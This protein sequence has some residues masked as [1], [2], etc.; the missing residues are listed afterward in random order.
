MVKEEYSGGRWIMC[1]RF[2]LISNLSEV[3][4]V[5]PVEEISRPLHR[6][7]N[8]S[9][10]TAVS[11]LVR[12]EK[13]KLVQFRWGQV[14]PWAREGKP[15]REM[16]NAR[17]ETV[18]SKPAFRESFLKRRCLVLSNGYY[19][20]KRDGKGK[21][22][23]FIHLDGN[24]LFAFAG[25]YDR[26]DGNALPGVALLT[27]EPAPSIRSIH[28]RMPVILTGGTA[29]QWIGPLEGGGK[30]LLP[31]LKPYAGGDLSAYAVS[32][33]VNAPSHD[34]PACIAPRPGG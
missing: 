23:Y 15:R 7:F 1:G 19:E 11:A 18:A 21:I 32:T 33:C 27:T 24:R 17:A 8:I 25:I 29:D 12:D 14:P 10:G 4:D 3:T 13:G 22:P 26:T 16:I 6:S 9:P 2:V 5:F 20:W 28:E 30:N 31:L 34:S